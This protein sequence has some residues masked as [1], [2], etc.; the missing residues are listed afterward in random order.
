MN[1]L[2]ARPLVRAAPARAA[3]QVRTKTTLVPPK[4]AS[5]K[6]LGRLQSVHPQHH[7]EIFRKMKYFY[8]HIPKGS[9]QDTTPKSWWERYKK[10][11][12]NSSTPILHFFMIAMP[13]GYVI[14]YVDRGVPS[15]WGIC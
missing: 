5:L 2:L 6:E 14:Q 9:K 7:P 15:P 4:V 12:G 1:A 8:E 13:F 11:Y 3:V 10:K